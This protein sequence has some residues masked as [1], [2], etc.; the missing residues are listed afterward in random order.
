M[1]FAPF[2]YV[3][4]CFLSVIDHTCGLY[5]GGQHFPS[6]FPVSGNHSKILGVKPKVIVVDGV[7]ICLE[8]SGRVQVP[9]HQQFPVFRV[10]LSQKT[11][12]VYALIVAKPAPPPLVAVV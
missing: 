5:L 3:E 7:P 12:L 1:M 8:G 2:Q 10:G 9:L 6:K 4:D 11:K